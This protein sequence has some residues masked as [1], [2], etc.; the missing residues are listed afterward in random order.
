MR[1]RRMQ[2]RLQKRFD[3]DAIEASQANDMAVLRP[4]LLLLMA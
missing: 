2:R 4:Q 3:A 1:N